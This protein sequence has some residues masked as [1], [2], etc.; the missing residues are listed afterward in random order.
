MNEMKI[1][2][3]RG[4]KG[5]TLVEIMIVLSVLAIL[6]A[7][8]VPSVAGYLGRSKE[9]AWDA[10]RNILQASVDSYRTDIGKR[11]GNPWPTSD[12]KTIGKPTVT[13]NVTDSIQSGKR[14]G[15]IDIGALASE[16]YL[17]SAD[18]VKS[19]RTGTGFHNTAGNT[20]SG[21]YVWYIDTKGVV[22][23]I[24]FAVT[25][26]YSSSTWKDDFVPDVYP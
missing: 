20:V 24:C 7:V 3:R 26:D 16:N 21:S 13:D 22:H 25:S 18:A 14:Y 15:I 1:G 11:S 12:N 2:F 10:D 6:A 19:A 8:I 9:R 17:K 23:S 4:E 5:F